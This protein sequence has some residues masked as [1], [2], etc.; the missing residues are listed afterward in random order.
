MSATSLTYCCTAVCATGSGRLA[1][2]ARPVEGTPTSTLHSTITLTLETSC[3]PASFRSCAV[4]LLPLTGPWKTR[5]PYLCLHLPA[6]CHTTVTRTRRIMHGRRYPA[7]C[8]SALVS[9]A[10]RHAL[11]CVR[12]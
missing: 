11:L 12:R 10:H 7:G 1:S 8:R 4:S 3:M 6:P 2:A 9:R 5:Y